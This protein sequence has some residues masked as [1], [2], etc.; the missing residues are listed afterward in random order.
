MNGGSMQRVETVEMDGGLAVIL[1]QDVLSKLNV[2][3]GDS[4]HV[5]V[6]AGGFNLR[7]ENSPQVVAFAV[8]PN[9]DTEWK[10]DPR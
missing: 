2:G 3:L 9:G 7:S 6:V 5:D 8:V 1:S 10:V 4:V